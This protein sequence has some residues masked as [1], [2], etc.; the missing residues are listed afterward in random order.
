MADLPV[1]RVSPGD[2]AFTHAGLDFFEPFLVKKGRGTEK[3]YGRLF[4]CLN[5]RAVHIEIAHSMDTD[6]FVNCLLR[7]IA[8]RGQPKMIR[9]DNGRNF[10][11]GERELRE[12][13]DRWMA[14]QKGVAQLQ[15]ELSN[16]RITWKFNVPYA[17][18]MVGVW[19]RQIRTIRRVLSG[20]SRT[21][22]LSD[23]QL[24]TLMTVSE[25]LVNNRPLTSV[26][27]D[28]RDMESLT[29][30]HLL[31][32][33]PVAVPPGLFGE[34]DLCSRKK[35]RH[36]QYLADLFWKRWIRE[37]LPLLRERTKWTKP[38]ENVRV[39]DLV[40]MIDFLLPRNE[41]VLARVLEVFPGPDGYVRSAR[42]R[43]AKGELVRPISK[44]CKLER[45]I[46][47]DSA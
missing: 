47:E 44:L 1:D 27:D 6:S 42:I 33:K 9:S 14:N 12:E 19:E 18:H 20:L 30:N 31:L 8:R 39:G 43:T 23:E 21:H 38:S 46:A 35:W 4:T 5:T 45:N 11:S 37:Y 2:P 36:T 40:I 25:G 10:V 16:R 32:L 28:P 17:S 22:R 29:P 41:W 7:F 13:Y 26:S 15:H 34:S 24:V 3:R